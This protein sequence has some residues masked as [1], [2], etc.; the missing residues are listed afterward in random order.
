MTVAERVDNVQQGRHAIL[1]EL[2][3]AEDLT[4][5]R[6]PGNIGDHLIW[7]GTRELL[8]GQIYREVGLD[9]VAG[10]RGHTAVITGGGAFCGLYNW[11]LRLLPVVELRFER[12]VV[13]PQSFDLTDDGVRRCLSR[14]SATIFAREM[15]SFEAIT[16]L[17]DARLACDCAF[18]FDFAPFIRDGDGVLNAF[19]TDLEATGLVPLPAGNNDISATAADLAEWIETI[20]SHATVR[21]DRAHVMIAAALLGKQVQWAPNSYHKVSA[22]ADYSLR[23]YPSVTPL[24]LTPPAAH[25]PA[26]TRA[27]RSR[28]SARARVT[29]IVLCHNRPE[30]ALAAI[31]SIAAQGPAVNTVVLDNN[32]RRGDAE[33]LAAG[34]AE[35]DGV[36]LRRSDRNLGCAGGRRLM[37]EG[38]SSEFVLLL[39]DDAEL[40]P[41]ALEL[42][43]ADLDEHPDAGGITATVIDGDGRVMHSGGWSIVTADL[44]ELTSIGSGLPL[45]DAA[46]PPSGP[47]D[48]LPNTASLV[49][50]QLFRDV[51]LDDDMRAYYEDAEWSHRVHTSRPGAFRRSREAVAVHRSLP[52]ARVA[53]DFESRSA[54]AEM[55]L[56]QAYFYRRHGL[57]L[58][59]D[60][61]ALVP[62]LERPDGSV[63]L[64]AL[65]LMLEL[66]LARGT[67]WLFTQWMNGGLEPLFD[68]PRMQAEQDLAQE[69]IAHADKML[70]VLQERHMTLV[71]IENGG[72]WR[73]RSRL[74]PLLRV[75]SRLRNGSS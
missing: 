10:E 70:Q 49:R 43:I 38:I 41:G 59:A 5:V 42:L 53:V 34:C 37:L 13:L 72:W 69:R 74:L 14:S 8:S 40:A 44:V 28:P 65:R 39:D 16:P 33:L 68:G 66:T 46:L 35:R 26:A 67:D 11:M 31:D 30:L 27:K 7:A 20:A 71:R 32:H 58:W 15:T 63:D 51:P 60:L 17:C 75:A 57:L 73:L 52:K 6:G 25:A 50:T 54:D 56:A 62:E 61:P 24:P 9:Q 22:I 4:F 21:T 45:A 36:V 3:D 12:V 55:L 48:W 29:A 23:D 1:Q 47:S 18:F 64:A 2:A 19:R